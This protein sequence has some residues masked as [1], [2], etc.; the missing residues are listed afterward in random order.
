MNET[1]HLYN[2]EHISFSDILTALDSNFD[3][4]ETSL[5]NFIDY[6]FDKENEA[7]YRFHLDNLQLH[8][9]GSDLSF[10]EDINE[11]I[12]HI[13]SKKNNMLLEMN[14]FKWK[15]IESYLIE[16]MMNTNKKINLSPN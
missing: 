4:K 1:F 7:K 16:K 5:E 6:I 13:T 12:F 10:N 2:P 9:I 8:G 14:G 3:V 15:G 11:T